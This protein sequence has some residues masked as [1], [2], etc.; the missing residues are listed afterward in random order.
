VQDQMIRQ[1][2]TAAVDP[3]DPDSSQEMQLA[4]DQWHQKVA[5]SIYFKFNALAK[6]AFARSRS[7]LAC[8]VAYTVNRNHQLGNIRMLQNSPNL[9]FNTMVYGVLKSMN[10][11]QL[12]EF[13]MGSRRMTVEKTGTFLWNFQM[14]GYKYQTNDR[15]TIQQRQR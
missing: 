14:D 1:T 9:I 10:N 8:R 15:E 4:W 12:L 13:P 6:T 3:N 7:R 2:P 5:E 11:N